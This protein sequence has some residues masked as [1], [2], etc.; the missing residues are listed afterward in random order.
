MLLQ[1]KDSE[2]WKLSSDRAAALSSSVIATKLSGISNAWKVPPSKHNS[3]LSLDSSAFRPPADV[4]APSDTTTFTS[5]YSSHSTMAGIATDTDDTSSDRCLIKKSQKR[6]RSPLGIDVT[7]EAQSKFLATSTSQRL[8]GSTPS[9][10]ALD[11]FSRDE[12]VNSTSRQQFPPVD[13]SRRVEEFSSRACS[14]MPL[15]HDYQSSADSSKS[16]HLLPQQDVAG[17][18]TTS[19]VSSIATTNHTSQSSVISPV[20]ASPYLPFL[21][22]TPSSNVSGLYY[23]SPYVMLSAP[24]LAYQQTAQPHFPCG[25]ISSVVGGPEATASKIVAEHRQQLD[26]QLYRL[27]PTSTAFD[28]PW[29]RGNPVQS[30]QFLTKPSPQVCNL[31]EGH[32]AAATK[33]SFGFNQYMLMHNVSSLGA[34]LASDGLDM[35]RQPSC[36]FSPSMAANR[37]LLDSHPASYLG[38]YPQLFHPPYLGIPS[39]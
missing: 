3:G 18:P 24:H 20:A 5:L 23:P 26:S 38:I 34:A 39:R 9:L 17:V 1:K 29:M 37:A 14:L 16:L 6:S 33:P 11:S 30:N 31:Y 22:S 36:D 13:K 28:F 25:W 7:S 35:Y 4:A 21:P 19:A 15:C 2:S 12:P 10:N 32:L 27:P 8:V